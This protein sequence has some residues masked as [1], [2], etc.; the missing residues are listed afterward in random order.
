MWKKYKQIIKCLEIELEITKS[1]AK[2]WKGLYHDAII[3]ADTGGTWLECAF[4]LRADKAELQKQYDE[5]NEKYIDLLT[6]HEIL[7]GIKKENKQ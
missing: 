2:F 1:D 7:L 4:K 5:L 6:K 3:K